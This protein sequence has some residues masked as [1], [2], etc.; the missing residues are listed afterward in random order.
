MLAFLFR[1]QVLISALG[2]TP[3]ISTA[4]LGLYPCR[5]AVTEPFPLYQMTSQFQSLSTEVNISKLKLL[6]YL[7]QIYLG[8]NPVVA[9]DATCFMSW[10]AKEYGLKLPRDYATKETCSKS[11]GDKTDIN[12]D[13]CW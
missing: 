10:I 3:S 11:T 5:K 9:T 4:L 2:Q 12:K 7:T 8:E 1:V 6:M 13:V